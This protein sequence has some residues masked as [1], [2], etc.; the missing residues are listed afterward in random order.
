MRKIELLAPAGSYESL[1]AAYAAGADAVYAGGTKF[2]ARAYAENFTEEQFLQAMDYAHLHGKKLYLTVNTLLKSKELETQLYNYLAPLYERGLDGIIIQ[3]MGVLSFLKKAFPLLPIHGST[4]MTVTGIDSALFLKEQGIERIVPARELS[5]KE[6]KHMKKICG[7]EL[8]VFIHGALCYCYSGQCFFS[9]LV[10]GR[11]GNRGRCAQP[12]RLPYT[13]NDRTCHILSPKDLCGL[14]HIPELYAAGVDSFKIE[15]RMKSAAYT[16]GVVSVY[17][18]YLDLFYVNPKSYKVSDADIEML[19]DIYNRGQMT[20]G[21]FHKHNS[22]KMISPDRPNHFGLLVG[23]T[24]KIADKPLSVKLHKNLT[25]GDVLELRDKGQQVLY[26]IVVARDY[27]QKENYPIH[28]NHPK[29]TYKGSESKKQ[30]KQKFLKHYLPSMADGT[31]LFLY[32]MKNKALIAKLEML[33]KSPLTKGITGSVFLTPRKKACFLLS[34]E[35]ITTSVEGAVVQQA[36]NQPLSKEQ[37]IAQLSKTGGT[38]FVMKELQCHVDGNVFLSK[39]EL[40]A[41][42]RAGLAAFEQALLNSYRRT[43]DD[44]LKNEIFVQNKPKAKSP[45]IRCNEKNASGT[46]CFQ[47]YTLTASVET[48]EQLNALLPIKEISRIDID[49]CLYPLNDKTD[50]GEFREAYTAVSKSGKLVYHKLPA[51]FRE[52][53]RVHY[54]KWFPVLMELADGFVVRNLDSYAYIIEKC[55]A[56]SVETPIICDFSLHAFQSLAADFWK[57]ENCRLTAPIELNSQELKIN[58]GCYDELVVY[59][60]YPMMISANCVNRTCKYLAEGWEGCNHGEDML[61]LADRYQ[62]IFPV[63]QFCNDCYNIIYNSLP[64]SLCENKKEIDNL[65]ISNLRLMF[66]TENHSQVLRVVETFFDVFQREIERCLPSDT[67]TRGH[68]KRGVE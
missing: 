14:A 30:E 17:R 23:S 42:R 27:K 56:F 21:Y 9:S 29:Q 64:L 34:D 13:I 1:L 3:D 44:S 43:L 49:S 51:I 40:N 25:K 45:S 18:K 47:Q 57:K 66:T 55:K 60:R 50:E 19:M 7:L 35:T 63:K 65:H 12:C 2:G 26:E 4:Q 48:K 38:G 39:Q 61:Y 33:A 59:G 53:T 31:T 24:K 37:I 5:T 36:Q 15:G 28:L 68:F 22:G 32:R 58:N 11:S 46:T 6:L 52:R 20:D 62:K 41:L 16:A 54:E 67:F 10:G 8:E